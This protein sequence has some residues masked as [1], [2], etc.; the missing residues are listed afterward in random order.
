MF[1][2]IT[3]MSCGAG[4]K[5]SFNLESRSSIAEGS[6]KDRKQMTD[7]LEPRQN[8]R[9]KGGNLVS[10]LKRT[11]S[12]A[13]HQTGFTEKKKKKKQHKKQRTSKTPKMREQTK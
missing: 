2:L 1:S 12:R 5:Y 7:G 8:I 9:L 13:C 10:K 4:H 3:M 11:E 6:A